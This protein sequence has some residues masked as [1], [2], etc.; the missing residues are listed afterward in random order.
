M[1][2]NFVRFTGTPENSKRGTTRRSGSAPAHHPRQREGAQI[3]TLAQSPDQEGGIK[4]GTFDPVVGA[5][6]SPL[7]AGGGQ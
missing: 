4:I 2:W 1:I 6:Q 5:G 7:A 3:D